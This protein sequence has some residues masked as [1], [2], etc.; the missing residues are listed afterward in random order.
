VGGVRVVCDTWSQ[1][2]SYSEG[3][4][5]L[6]RRLNHDLDLLDGLGGGA[7]PIWYVWYSK[8]GSFSPTCMY[9]K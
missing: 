9:R 3:K 5:Y 4:K 1:S 7:S 2:A 6:V 8:S